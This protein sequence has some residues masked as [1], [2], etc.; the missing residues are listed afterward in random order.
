[1]RGPFRES[2]P[3]EPPPHRAEFGFSLVPCGPLPARGARK[4]VRAGRRVYLIDDVVCAATRADGVARAN[5]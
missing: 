3:V 5:T 2:E 1:M 4:A